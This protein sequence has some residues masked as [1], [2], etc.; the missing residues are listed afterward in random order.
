MRLAQGFSRTERH[1]RALPL[2]LNVRIGQDTQ[3]AYGRPANQHLRV[4]RTAP[5]AAAADER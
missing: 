4:P 5:A 3:F 2:P 1:R